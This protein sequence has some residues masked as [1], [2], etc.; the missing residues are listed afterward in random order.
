MPKNESDAR[1]R[2]EDRSIEPGSV[3]PARAGATSLLSGV[4]AAAAH[5]A[6][7]AG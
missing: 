1:K 3:Q 5:R 2:A 4:T 6:G 7:R